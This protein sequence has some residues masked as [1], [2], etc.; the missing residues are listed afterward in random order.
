MSLS[1]ILT[2][3]TQHKDI[4]NMLNV[5]KNNPEL[6]EVFQDLFIKLIFFIYTNV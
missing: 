4:L 2:M 5:I 6:L 1:C 3:N